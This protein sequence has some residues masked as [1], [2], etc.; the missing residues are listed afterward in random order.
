M[1]GSMMKRSRQFFRALFCK[2]DSKDRAFIDQ[3]LDLAEKSLFNN[4]D[5]PVQK[6]CVNV[7]RTVQDICSGQDVNTGRIIK[8]ALIHDIGKTRGSF[9]L[10]HRVLYVIC[11]RL[12]PG[13]A[14]NIGRLK[15]GQQLKSGWF[16]RMQYAFYVHL[17]H[18]RLGAELARK[19]N[20]SQDIIFFIQNH[21]NLSMAA[22]SKELA[23][24][25]KADEMN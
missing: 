8:A 13:L 15:N 19:A 6:H 14:K 12:S 1:M 25:Y 24:L 4:M 17:N 20:L 23:V 5:V 10:T 3:Y 18:E 9:K 21:H 11:C 2:F 7:A 22:Q 16:N